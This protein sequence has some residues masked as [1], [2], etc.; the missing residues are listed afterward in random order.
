VTDVV[1]RPTV[2]ERGCVSVLL[3]E[4]VASTVKLK[5]PAVV[6][7]PEMK[8]PLIDSPGWSAPEDNDH[9]T[10]PTAPVALSWVV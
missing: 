10:V 7:V 2:I 8:A 5:S 6:G 4:S 9:V 3:A 1:P